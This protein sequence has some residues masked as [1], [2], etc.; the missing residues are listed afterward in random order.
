MAHASSAHGALARLLA[1]LDAF[2]GGPGGLPLRVV[3]VF[4]NRRV[5]QVVDYHRLSSS[6]VHD[7]A[8]IHEAA[9]R[10]LA[11]AARGLHSQLA[12][13]CDLPAAAMAAERLRG[14]LGLTAPCGLVL[15]A[16]SVGGIRLVGGAGGGNHGD[17]H[18][19][20]LRRRLE[21][22]RSAVEAAR[23]SFDL[24]LTAVVGGGADAAAAGPGQDLLRLFAS[25]AGGPPP[26]LLANEGAE[27]AAEALGRGV[28]GAF[29][30]RRGRP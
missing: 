29:G 3:I 9:R 13:D 1:F 20:W 7:A 26:L 10:R 6:V 23:R 27:A 21:E 18:G 22:A 30:D 11:A 24:L 8:Q 4:F 16:P 14:Q 15:L 5:L 2:L 17:D 25:A 28:C 19:I 12:E